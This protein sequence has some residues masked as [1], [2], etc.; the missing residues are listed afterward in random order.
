MLATLVT[1]IGTPSSGS[2]SNNTYIQINLDFLKPS[3]DNRIGRL[4]TIVSLRTRCRKTL[5]STWVV[6][7]RE[8]S[9]LLS[10][11]PEILGR[12]LLLDPTCISKRYSTWK[13]LVCRTL[14]Y[15][16]LGDENKKQN[17]QDIFSC[18]YVRVSKSPQIYFV[19]K[20]LGISSPLFDTY[21]IGFISF[22]L[23]HSYLSFFQQFF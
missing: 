11:F 10:W 19:I 6:R 1:P 12:V 20:N 23:S 17:K 4:T 5:S 21:S 8:R 18:N 9:S 14:Q 7:L 22:P 16:T 2:V 3:L 13:T 15:L